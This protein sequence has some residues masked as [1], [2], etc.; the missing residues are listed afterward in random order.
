MDMNLMQYKLSKYQYLLSIN[1]SN[2]AIYNAKIK[3]YE[4]Q[5]GGN[6][7]YKFTSTQDLHGKKFKTKEGDEYCAK[8]R[9]VKKKIEKVK[10]PK[11]LTIDQLNSLRYHSTCESG[12]IGTDQ[13]GVHSIDK[14]HTDAIFNGSSYD[15]LDLYCKEAVDK[16]VLSPEERTNCDIKTEHCSKISVVKDKILKKEKNNKNTEKCTS[17]DLKASFKG[18]KDKDIF[19][20]GDYDNLTQPCKKVVDELKDLPYVPYRE[21]ENV[22]KEKEKLPCT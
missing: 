1:P 21:S 6:E 18:K 13:M 3:Y 20:M 10:P 12:F 9:T 8:Y 11:D 4:N 19:T 22:F 7:N 2:S 14:I 17:N 16:L 15:Y 5:I